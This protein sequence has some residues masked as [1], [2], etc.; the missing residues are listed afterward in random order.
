MSKKSFGKFILF[1]L[2]TAI[3]A[4]IGF[5]IY[6]HL[7]DIKALIYPDQYTT[8]ETV[9]EDAEM[10]TVGEL[11]DP[12]LI[13]DGVRITATPEDGYK[14]WAFFNQDGEL[15][16]LENPF[17]YKVV[18]GEKVVAK[19][20]NP[21]TEVIITVLKEVTNLDADKVE[22]SVVSTDKKALDSSVELTAE[23]GENETFVGFY[24]EDGEELELEASYNFT[25]SESIT[26]TMKFTYTEPTQEVG[27]WGKGQYF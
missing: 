15:L 14:F 27:A 24:N 20:Y 19:F 25:A 17:D 22:T 5:G 13:G 10:G 16:S 21:E 8:V 11:K 18:A 3:V 1:L 12:Q 6:H 26:I 9:T 2:A 23:A 7:N 4:T